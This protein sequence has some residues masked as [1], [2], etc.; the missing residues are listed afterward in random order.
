MPPTTQK[1]I[2]KPTEKETVS[3]NDTLGD[4]WKVM[5]PFFKFSVKAIKLMARVLVFIVKHVPR[6]E[7]DQPKTKNGKVIKIG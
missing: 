6:P 3:L 7:Q 5:K 4:T 1:R 2:G